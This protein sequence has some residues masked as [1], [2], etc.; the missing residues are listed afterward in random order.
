[1]NEIEILVKVLESKKSALKKL[2]QFNCTGKEK[3]VDTYFFDPKRKNLKPINN[4]LNECFRLRK[5]DNNCHI[6]Y[7]KDIFDKNNKWIYS[8]EYETKISNY[9][10]M[11]SIL[12]NLG[13]KKLIE[14]QNTK[15]IFNTSK[16]E[17]VLEEVKHL[18]LFLEVEKRGNTNK[19]QII[20]EKSNI[21]KFIKSLNMNT[22]K[23]LNCG[24]PE[25]MLKLKKY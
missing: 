3:V 9:T 12:T 4:K 23:E 7:K 13:F 25:L 20:K 22:G 21:K 14:I 11:K 2:E 19:N 17:I 5:K 8:K 18:G 1:M 10:I 6:T 15:H 24:K 16:Y